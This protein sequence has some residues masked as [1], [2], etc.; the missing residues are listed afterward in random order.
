M[1]KVF[2]STKDKEN[3]VKDREKAII[4]NFSKTFNK[5]KRLD[6]GEIAETEVSEIF[7]WSDKEKQAKA[8]EKNQAF[9]QAA[10]AYLQSIANSPKFVEI[11]KQQIERARQTAIENAMKRDKELGAKKDGKFIFKTNT[12]TTPPQVIVQYELSN[13]IPSTGMSSTPTTEE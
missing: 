13:A 2:L 7:G 9:D 5:I 11:A 10:Q 12:K 3:L 8:G 4:E 6:E 1:K